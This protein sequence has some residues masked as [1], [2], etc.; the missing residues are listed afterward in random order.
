MMNNF[1]VQCNYKIVR[2]IYPNFLC[3]ADNLGREFTGEEG[4]SVSGG[5]QVNNNWT[6]SQCDYAANIGD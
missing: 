4:W 1:S 2:T 6:L 3:P 5:I